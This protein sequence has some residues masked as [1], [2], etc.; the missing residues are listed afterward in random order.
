MSLMLKIPF[1]MR[2]PVVMV[3][4]KR[5]YKLTHWMYKKLPR[6]HILSSTMS[7][8][9]S[10]CVYFSQNIWSAKCINITMLLSSFHDI[11]SPFVSTQFRRH[12]CCRLKRLFFL[13]FIIRM[14]LTPIFM[15][16]IIYITEIFAS[17]VF[18]I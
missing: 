18:R 6:Q 10:G 11:P 9:W 5:H 12:Y 17:G 16:I 8:K 1:E 14:L 2:F 3:L 15:Q 13:M 4:I 7:D